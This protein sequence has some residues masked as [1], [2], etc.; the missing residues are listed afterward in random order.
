M[1]MNPFCDRMAVIGAGPCGLA[2]AKALS[3]HQI[4]YDQFEA[5]DDLGGNPPPHE[6][7]PLAP[8]LLDDPKGQPATSA[9][10]AGPHAA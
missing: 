1:P 8:G 9:T 7:E 3:E 6:T 10:T 5:D 2:M 4:P